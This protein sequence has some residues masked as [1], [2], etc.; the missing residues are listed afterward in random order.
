MQNE[1]ALRKTQ[2]ATKEQHTPKVFWGMSCCLIEFLLGILFAPILGT[3]ILLAFFSFSE[4]NRLPSIQY[5][6]KSHVFLAEKHVGF[7][8]QK[9]EGV[10]RNL[11]FLLSERD[12]DELDYYK[13]D[14]YIRCDNKIIQLVKQGRLDKNLTLMDQKISDNEHI[15]LVQLFAE[16]VA[17]LFGKEWKQIEAIPHITILVPAPWI[18]K[19]FETTLVLLHDDS[20]LWGEKVDISTD[21]NTWHHWPLEIE[22]IPTVFGAVYTEQ[23]LEQLR[24]EKEKKAIELEERLKKWKAAFEKGRDIF[25]KGKE[26]FRDDNNSRRH[27]EAQ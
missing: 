18:P 7:F 17:L 26:L 27:S 20:R 8:R 9:P 22:S 15:A 24:K 4:R 11:H 16:C 5:E 10:V 12:G 3:F 23:E 19:P 13:G 25:Q 6:T 21:G 1:N 14:F 2:H